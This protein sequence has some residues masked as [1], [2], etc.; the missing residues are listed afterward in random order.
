MVNN[1]FFLKIK[2]S[3]T[4][5]EI[6]NLTG[7]SVKKEVDHN[8]LCTSIGAIDKAQ[9]TEI[10]FL[11]SSKYISKLKDSNAGF[12]LI[13]EKNLDKLNNKTIGIINQDPYLA[14]AKISKE[15]YRAIDPEFSE[16]YIHP[17]VKMGRNCK[18]S[19]RAYIGKNVTIGDNT[20]IEPYSI[21][22]DGCSIGSNCRIY[23]NVTIAFAEIGNNCIIH[24]GVRIGQDG[25][26]FTND[27]GVNYKII[28]LGTVKIGNDVEIG[29]NTCI[30][31]GA[32]NDTEIH[33][34]VKIDNLC[35]I[36]HNVEIGKGTVIA[37]CSAIAGSTKIGNYTQIGGGCCI[38]G[39]IEIGNFVKIAGMSGVM[40]D[41]ENNEIIA[42]IPTL[43][44]KKWHKVNA[45]LHG[46]ID[47]INN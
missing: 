40:R 13:E 25:F 19:S 1:K 6:I 14:Y 46:L 18:I 10:T 31:R 16:Q 39:H 32:I 4:I 17:K 27:N 11:S 7:S 5:E 15:F 29:A 36:A 44:I 37:G 8:L 34:L 24:P 45:H 22:L 23:S 21:I 9:E 35:Q 28:Q 38:N 42:G 3:I 47:K 20:I 43:P 2:E 26:G 41:V 12:C 30:D 33:D